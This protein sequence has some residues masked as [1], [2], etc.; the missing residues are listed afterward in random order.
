MAANGSLG[1]QVVGGHTNIN[2]GLTIGQNITL[3]PLADMGDV[4]HEFGHVFDNH[5]AD[6]KGFKSQGMIDRFNQGSCSTL[7]CAD[8]TWIL[9]SLVTHTEY[10]NKSPEEDFADS[11]AYTIIYG[12]NDMISDSRQWYILSLIFDYVYPYA[13]HMGR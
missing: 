9:D 7:P 10:A 12:E 13:H 4:V 11:F 3:T 1:T 5:D 6:K 2:V 8:G